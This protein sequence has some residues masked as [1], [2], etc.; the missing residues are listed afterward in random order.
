MTLPQ[1]LSPARLLAGPLL[2][3]APHPDDETLGAGGVLLEAAARGQAAW[4]VF[5]TSG[6]A[7]GWSLKY[8]WR[9]LLGDKSAMLDLGRERMNEALAA[10]ARLGVPPERVVFL[11]F[12]DRGMQALAAAHFGRPYRSPTTNVQEVPYSRA[13]RPGAPYTGAEFEAQLRDLLARIRPHTVLAPGPL[14]GHPDHRAIT[15][16]VRRVMATVAGA[17]LLYYLVHSG[18][19]WPRPKGYR[20][21]LR[22]TAP[23]AYRGASFL[24][25]VLSARQLRA[26]R[27]AIRAYGSQLGLLSW[28]LW[29]FLRR[30]ELLLPAERRPAPFREVKR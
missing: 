27:D 6:D 7:F 4:V 29:S 18:P 11:G 13:L 22:F 9:R 15:G 21:L 23:P 2:V 14:D 30:D 20:P 24:R 25:H 5:V 26:K 10:A 28:N 8:L 16:M 17:R 1:P 19:D 3:I 12:P